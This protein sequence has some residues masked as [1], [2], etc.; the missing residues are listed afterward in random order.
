MVTSATLTV[1]GSFTYVRARLGL[2]EAAEVQVG[3]PFDYEEQGVLFLPGGLPEPRDPDFI[4]A[5]SH[6]VRQLLEISRGRAFLLFTSFAHLGAMREIL[7]RDTAHP[8]LT[9]GEAPRE[10]LLERFRRTPGA[11]LLGSASFWEGV[12]VPGEA[13][14]LVVIDRLPFAVPDDPLLAARLDSIRQ[15]GGNPFMDYQ[16]PEAVLALKQGAGRLIRSRRDRG[17]LCILDPRLV[18]RR[19]GEAFARSLPPFRPATELDEVR[20]FFRRQ[21]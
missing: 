3:S 1:T 9:Q 6:V 21:G 12:D 14:S 13:L 11:V 7:A 10:F 8:L 2:A 18:W 20:S 17:I 5:A 16:V 15:G 19:Y 4:P